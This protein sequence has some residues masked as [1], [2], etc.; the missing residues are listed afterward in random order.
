[1]VAPRSWMESPKVALSIWAFMARIRSGVARTVF[2]AAVVQA[3]GLVKEAGVPGMAAAAKAT[4]ADRQRAPVKR[5]IRWKACS[6][7]IT[8]F[9]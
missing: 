1:M 7:M 9:T 3:E 4:D 2:P 8:S 5:D 6:K